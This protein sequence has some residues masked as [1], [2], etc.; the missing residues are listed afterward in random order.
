MPAQIKHRNITHRVASAR[1]LVAALT[2]I[3]ADPERIEAARAELTEANAEATI[4]RLPKL[5]V[6]A[7]VRLAYL[8]L[9]A[10]GSDGAA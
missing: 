3:G 6:E 10:G 9:S 5:P 2:S 1:G 4:I 7:R 8:I